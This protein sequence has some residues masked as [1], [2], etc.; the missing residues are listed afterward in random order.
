MF[1]RDWDHACF[2]VSFDGG[3]MWQEVPRE[4]YLLLQE[5]PTANAVSQK[6]AKT[7]FIKG[8]VRGRVVDLWVKG[9]PH[10]SKE[11]NGR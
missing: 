4:V 2:Y 11:D 10:S 6:Q 8:V 9:T 1:K 3:R 7:K 5:A